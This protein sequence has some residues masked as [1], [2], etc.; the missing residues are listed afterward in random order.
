MTKPLLWAGAWVR[1]FSVP[2]LVGCVAG[3]QGALLDVTHAEEP[4][5]VH[6]VA[7]PLPNV[8]LTEDLLY[9]LLVAEIAG[10]RGESK[11]AGE[12][13]LELAKATRDPR[14]AQRAAQIAFSLKD[15]PMALA[16]LRLW[17]EFAPNSVEAR[18]GL[19]VLLVREGQSDAGVP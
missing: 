14:V 19:V 1:L 5:K 6:G 3:Q 4:A 13:Y 7:P 9:K 17:A 12:R 16:A 18:Q 2:L 15:Q 8:P 11:L 10:Q